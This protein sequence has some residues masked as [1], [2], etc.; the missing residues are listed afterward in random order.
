M[1]GKKT[2]DDVLKLIAALSDD[3][4]AKLM[5]RIGV[6]EDPAAEVDTGETPEEVAE[7][8][9]DIAP[10]EEVN[11]DAEETTPAEEAP[12]AETADAPDDP[13]AEPSAENDVETP[14]SDNSDPTA[15]ALQALAERFNSLQNSFENR[16]QKVEGF[17]DALTSEDGKQLDAM[18]LQRMADAQKEGRESYLD[19]RKRVIGE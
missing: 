3:E 12:S 4:R 2:A 8:N 10:E 13:P 6:T 18:G 15:E 5:Q 14:E 7:E 16:L 17:I 11:E 19:L 1:F 9:T